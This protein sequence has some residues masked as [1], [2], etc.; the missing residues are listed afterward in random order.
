MFFVLA[1]ALA[2]FAAPALAQSAMIGSGGV[3]I[4]GQGIF[5]TGAGAF[6]FPA[7]VNANYDSIDVGNDRARAIGVGS[8]QVGLFNDNLRQVTAQNNLKIKKNQDT[9]D[10]QTCT[11]CSPKYNIEQVKVGSRDALAIGVGGFQGGFFNHNAVSVLAQNNVEIVTNQ[12]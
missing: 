7:A 5:E 10:A 4:L 12:Q 1:M 3:D 8:A 2:A 11:A 9:G 6:K